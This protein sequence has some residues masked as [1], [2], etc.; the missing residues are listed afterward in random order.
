M[1]AADSVTQW[2]VQFKIGD[3]AAAH[4]LWERYF[5]QL[6]ARARGRLAGVPRRAS[7]EEDVALS[8]FHSFCRAAAQGRFPD[9]HDRDDLWKVLLVITDRKALKLARHEGCQRR[10][11]G[12]VRDEAACEDGRT[13]ADC[14]AQVPAPEPAPELAVLVADECR[15][16]LQ[17]L[18]NAQVQQVAVLRLEGYTIPEIAGQVGRA[19][20]T[21][22]RWLQLI[23]RTWAKELERGSQEPADGP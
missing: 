13:A 23:R 6:G 8:A 22:K 18:G 4:A 7:D 2:I 19:P 16:L 21:V 20:R 17:A 3:P 10:G 15:H 11:G 1:S 12:Q 5:R 9:L 14:L